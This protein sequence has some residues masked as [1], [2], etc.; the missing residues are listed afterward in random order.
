VGV[1]CKPKADL[2][3]F[4]MSWVYEFEELAGMRMSMPVCGA[5]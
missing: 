5:Q 3:L 2:M 4:A 1:A